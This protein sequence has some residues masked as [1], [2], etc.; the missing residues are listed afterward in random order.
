MKS[1]SEALA[2][3][4]AQAS[5]NGAWHALSTYATEFNVGYSVQIDSPAIATAATI[6]VHG[7][8]V[9][10]LADG[11]PAAADIFLIATTAG[12]PAIGNAIQSAISTPI[13]AI[14]VTITG[15]SSDTT[16][17]FRYLQQGL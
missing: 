13:A 9:N 2:V 7:T 8:L 17:T 11:V 5:V 4:T 15:V 14:M 6:N 16:G 12:N 10:V 1:R 3:T